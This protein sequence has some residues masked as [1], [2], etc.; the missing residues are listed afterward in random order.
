MMGTRRR[1][2]GMMC[3]SLWRCQEKP[4][5][6]ARMEWEELADQWDGRGLPVLFIVGFVLKQ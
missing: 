2:G 4:L 6:L 5:D 1:T 3:T